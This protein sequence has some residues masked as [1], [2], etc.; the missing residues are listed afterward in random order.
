MSAMDLL[1]NVRWV[2]FGGLRIAA[3]RLIA[4]P[5][6]PVTIIG[7]PFGWAHLTRAGVSLWPIGKEVVGNA[8]SDLGRVVIKQ[9][10]CPLWSK[11]WGNRPAACG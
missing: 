7:I 6:A 5:I 11:R 10:A 9:A 2:I 8:W 4:A 3:G 1:L